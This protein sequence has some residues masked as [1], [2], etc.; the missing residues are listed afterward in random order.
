[1]AANEENKKID[2]EIDPSILRA[3][4]R[5]EGKERLLKNMLANRYDTLYTR[6]AA[7]L[8]KHKEARNSD[9]ELQFRYWESYEGYRMGANIT[10]EQLRDNTRLTSL[11]RAR[12]KIQNEF[13]LFGADPVV[14]EHR[15]DLAGEQRQKT[16]A[17]KPQSNPMIFVYADESGKAG[18]ETYLIVGSIWFNDMQRHMEVQND[19]RVWVA[20]NKELAEENQVRFPK[21]FHFTEMKKNQLDLYKQFF[22]KVMQFSDMVSFKAVAVKKSEIQY[23]TLEQSVYSLYYQLA[24]LGIEHEVQS[25][26]LSLPRNICYFKDADDG[27]DKLHLEETRQLLQ[28]RFKSNYDEELRLDAL[29]GMPSEIY[30]PVQIADLVTG[31]VSRKLNTPEGNNHK[32]QFAEYVL[33]KL[34]VDY[35]QHKVSEIDKGKTAANIEFKQEQDMFYVHL[36][37]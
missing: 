9:Q 15:Q 12:A 2:E 26:R 3:R 14:E 24:H 7:V 17:M 22:D 36:F 32:D 8:N 20:E 30:I 19:M 27:S 21:E 4:K 37:E 34:N 29:N 1:M 6:V 31:A 18:G 16:V 33:E 25:K 23:K 5:E 28:E 11:A 10:P 35:I 13:G